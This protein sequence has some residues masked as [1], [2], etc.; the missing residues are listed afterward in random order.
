MIEIYE[1]TLI[2]VFKVPLPHQV[3]VMIELSIQNLT[4]VFLED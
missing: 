1:T 4:E 2:T 3:Y